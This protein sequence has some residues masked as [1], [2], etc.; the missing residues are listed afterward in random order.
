MTRQE[1]LLDTVK[2][3]S[4]DTN[5]RCV[6]HVD[7]LPYCYYSPKY[8]QKVDISEGCGIGRKL[9]P[10]AQEAYDSKGGPIGQ[11][12]CSNSHK[13]MAPQWMQEMSVDFLIRLQSFHDSDPYWNKN[14]GLSEEGKLSLNYILYEYGLDKEVFLPY[15]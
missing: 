4:E 15:L 9:S 11:L 1:F 3:Y 7:G 5:R 6:M 13:R 10:E 8:A 14:E 2:Y 12:F